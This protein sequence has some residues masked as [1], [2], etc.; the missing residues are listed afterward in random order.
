MRPQ[1]EGSS[2]IEDIGGPVLMLVPFVLA[3]WWHQRRV[4]AEALGLGGPALARSMTRTG[5]SIVAIVGLAGLSAGLAW[6]LQ[7]LLDAAGST[8]PE[9]LITTPGFGDAGAQALALALVGFAMWIP[10]LGAPA[11]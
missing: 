5:R 7:V 4:S 2:L 8:T 11:A 6:G 10:G 3:W 9:S 1:T